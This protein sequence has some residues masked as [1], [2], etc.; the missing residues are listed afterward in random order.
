MLNEVF[1]WVKQDR[2]GRVLTLALGIV[3]I[4][5]CATWQLTKAP[6]L[7][8]VALLVECCA[9]FSCRHSQCQ[10]LSG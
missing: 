5:W 4:T 1:G 8:S 9:L 3:V 6:T 10:S 2:Q 7:D